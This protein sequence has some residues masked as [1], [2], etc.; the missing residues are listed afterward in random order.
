MTTHTDERRVA[1]SS[2]MGTLPV[3]RKEAAGSVPSAPTPASG[4]ESSTCA[5]SEATHP[6]S[7][8]ADLYTK[9]LGWPVMVRDMNVLLRCGEVADV[10]LMASGLAGEVNNS[11]KL[12][13][14]DAAV[15]E[16]TEPSRRWAFFCKSQPTSITNL[17]ALSL[18]GVAH[19]GNGSLFTL[20]PSPTC[21]SDSLRWICPP[22]PGATVLPLIAT[23]V[24]CAQTALQR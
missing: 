4:G 6:Q 15:M 20:P 18:H 22:T 14:L 17:G 9:G 23:V 13:G 3:M 5:S 7:P 2:A 16:L 19:Y 24:M 10:L 1:P 12:L 21:K 8:A 11:L